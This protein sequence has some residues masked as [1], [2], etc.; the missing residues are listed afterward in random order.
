MGTLMALFCLGHGEGDHHSVYKVSSSGSCWSWVA[1]CDP[2]GNW[3]GLCLYM[4]V[5]CINIPHPTLQS[6][7]SL[8]EPQGNSIYL[9]YRVWFRIFF[10][11]SYVW[12]FTPS[13]VFFSGVREGDELEGWL[14]QHR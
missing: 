6:L 2:T 13:S 9:W 8:L 10:W 1:K 5:K 4:L 7:W 11:L 12:Y 14:N 3:G